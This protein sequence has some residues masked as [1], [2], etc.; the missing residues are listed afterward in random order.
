MQTN[1]SCMKLWNLTFF[2]TKMRVRNVSKTLNKCLKLQ[3]EA[4]KKIIAHTTERVRLFTSTSRVHTIKNIMSSQSSYVMGRMQ[5]NGMSNIVW[6]E[7][8]MG[9]AEWAYLWWHC[10]VATIEESTQ[11]KFHT[12]THTLANKLTPKLFDGQF[13][14][15]TANRKLNSGDEEMQFFSCWISLFSSYFY[16][17]TLTFT[18]TTQIYHSWATWLTRIFSCVGIKFNVDVSLD[19]EEWIPFVFRRW[20]CW[21]YTQKKN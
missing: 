13:F 9:W 2:S 19:H 11:R 21:I 8:L 7:N 14:K 16:A 3:E 15:L 5:A 4:E 17:Y 10:R 20:K 18:L 1:E 12:K 6:H